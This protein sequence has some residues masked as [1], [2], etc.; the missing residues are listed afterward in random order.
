MKEFKTLFQKTIHK[1]IDI[2]STVDHVY[3]SPPIRLVDSHNTLS[4]L[5]ANVMVLL[6]DTIIPNIHKYKSELILDS[7][8]FSANEVDYFL[9]DPERYYFEDFVKLPEFSKQI[10]ETE[11]TLKRLSFKGSIIDLYI[12][13]LIELVNLFRCNIQNNKTSSEFYISNLVDLYTKFSLPKALIDLV[14]SRMQSLFYSPILSEFLPEIIL[15]TDNEPFG[16]KNLISKTSLF[17]DPL[18]R[19]IKSKEKITKEEFLTDSK[20]IIDALKEQFILP[21]H[22]IVLWSL[23]LSDIKHYGNDFG[24]FCNFQSILD[25]LAIKNN[26][27]KLQLTL[28]KQDGKNFIEFENSYSFILI[29]NKLIRT[30]TKISRVTNLIS[31]YL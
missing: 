13:R 31:I 26:L 5:D 30:N 23:A 2:I 4:A 11:T 27:H 25:N 19:N 6:W 8:I 18:F 15:L 21:S 9:F 20:R 3:G 17:K 10:S 24:F 29:G 12:E 7:S 14:S 16:L 28:P 1:E 22:E